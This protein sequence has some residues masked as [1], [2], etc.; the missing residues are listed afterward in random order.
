[1]FTPSRTVSPIQSAAPAHYLGVKRFIDVILALIILIGL[2][3]VELLIACLIKLTSPGPIFFRQR[4]EI[5]KDG[6]IF[7]LY[8][9][10]TMYVG[11]SEGINVEFQKNYITKNEPYKYVIDR[12]G[13][14]RPVYKVTD[15]PRVTRFGALLRRTGL[16]EMPQFINVLRG[17]MST[18]GP[19]PATLYEYEHYQPHHKQRLSVIPGITGLHQIR[20]RSSVGFDE[21]VK[22]DL[23]YI[24]R[25]SL[26]LDL[27]II[28]KT[29]WAMFFGKGAC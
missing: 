18:V 14:R 9:F 22:S 19:R 15:D 10:R 27:E 20:T 29:P 24:A 6:R 26:W 4:K 5:G 25:R 3:P 28:L 17:E 8:K 7:T 21:M 16:D 23:D 11:A 12:R 1:M 13:R 2:A